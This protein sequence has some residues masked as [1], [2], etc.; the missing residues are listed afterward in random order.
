MA[1]TESTSGV[2]SW[3]A[4]SS[5]VSQWAVVQLDTIGCVRWRPRPPRLSRPGQRPRPERT[6]SRSERSPTRRPGGG[7]YVLIRVG[8]ATICSPLGE[9]GL[10]VEVDHVE[11]VAPSGRYSSQIARMLAIARCDRGQP[12]DEQLEDDR[13]VT[14]LARSP[15]RS[16][17]GRRRRGRRR[18]RMGLRRWSFPPALG[19]EALGR[20]SRPTRTRS[21]FERSPMIFFTGSGSLRTSVGIARI[22]SPSAS[23]GFFIRS[24]T[25]ISY[26]PARC[27]S[28]IFFRLARAAMRLR[29]LAG[30]V[31]PQG[32]SSGFVRAAG[33]S[34]AWSSLWAVFRRASGLLRA[35]SR[36]RGRRPSRAPG[37]RLAVVARAAGLVAPVFGRRRPCAP[38]P[39][40]LKFGRAGASICA[41]RVFRLPLQLR[42]LRSAPDRGSAPPR[43]LGFLGRAPSRVR[44]PSA[45]GTTSMSSIPSAVSGTRGPGSSGAMP[46]DLRTYSAAVPLPAELDIADAATRCRS[47][48]RSR[49]RSASRRLAAGR[50]A[51]EQAGDLLGS[52]GSRTAGPAST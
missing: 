3:T 4:W 21:V 19:R 51:G 52:S 14:R 15:A 16:R 42:R 24:T 31:E 7:G 28:Q 33:S 11:V 9:V 18:G 34:A 6:T 32:H 20:M 35:C 8:V 26:R 25:S 48:T 43:G 37:H 40:R 45:R 29:R 2:R 41:S 5:L 50:Q 23:W 46:R 1:V 36:P 47:A 49:R 13:P 44:T 22:W 27:S 39:R 30:D 38:P 10:L 17:R 12:D